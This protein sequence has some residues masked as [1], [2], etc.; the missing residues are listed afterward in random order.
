MNQEMLTVDPRMIRILRLAE[1]VAASKASVLISGESGTGKE[2]LA[3]FIH[4]KSQRF[5]GP[6]VAVNCAAI[7]SGLIESELFGHERGSFTGAINQHAGQFEAAHNGTLFLDEVG[8]L[9][10][11]AQAKILRVLQEG[12]LRRVGSS[13]IRK[14]D[15]RVLAAT[16]RSLTE[17]IQKKEFRDD[18]YYRLKVVQFDLPPLRERPEDLKRLAR[19]F[20]A[21][22][23]ES[24]E[25]GLKT[26]STDA[27]RLLLSYSWPGNIRELQN[28]IESSVLFS[29]EPEI[30]PHDLQITAEEEN[31]N[32][33][34][35]GMKLEDVERI[36]IIKTLE[37]TNQNRT[38][39][40]DILGISIRTLR[41]KINEY[42][43]QGAL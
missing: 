33:I 13:S 2:L 36:L 11:E 41:N 25:R 35:P 31:G 26:F 29:Q 14:I 15:V 37:F 1:N 24:N 22:S 28:V 38:Q 17:M 23:C 40:A 30:Q 10:L 20:L 4:S 8:E 16:H 3:R 6:F 27:W 19:H 9:P 39:A 42:R 18:L 43:T 5:S 32:F 21:V 34:S 12:E 7:P